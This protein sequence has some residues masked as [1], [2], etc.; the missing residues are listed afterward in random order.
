MSE[1]AFVVSRYEMDDGNII[2]IRLQPETITTWNPAPASTVVAAGYPTAQ[3]NKSKRAYGIGARF[4]NLTWET[5]P[6]TGY[7]PGGYVKVP[8]LTTEA[9]E[10]LVYGEIVEY[11]GVNARVAGKTSESVK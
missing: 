6:P 4:V 9:Y 10:G 7:K 1:G 3:V 2:S 8:V 11:L 5:A